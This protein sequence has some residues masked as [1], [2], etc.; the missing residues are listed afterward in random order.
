MLLFFIKEFSQV[1]CSFIPQEIASARYF[2]L[3]Q[4]LVGNAN[5]ESLNSLFILDPFLLDLFGIH[6]IAVTPASFLALGQTL[7]SA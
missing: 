5:Y 1:F 4:G 6:D 2:L 7:K 3:M